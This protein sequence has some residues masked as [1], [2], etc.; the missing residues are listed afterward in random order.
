[1]VGEEASEV[2][3]FSDLPGTPPLA[4]RWYLGS[5]FPTP[6]PRTVLAP[7]GA[8]G[9]PISLISSQA[10]ISHFACRPDAPGTRLSPFVVSQAFPW[11]VGDS[12][13][14]LAMRVSPWRRSRIDVHQT[15]S[16]LRPLIHLLTSFITAYSPKRA[17]THQKAR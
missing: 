17:F 16:V 13:G 2:L 15:C 3:C 6:L 11:A 10:G 1:M 12:G 9:S 4:S 14:S 8:H 7:L 5:P